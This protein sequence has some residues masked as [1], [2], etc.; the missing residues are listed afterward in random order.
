MK[1]SQESNPMRDKYD[2][3]YKAYD[4]DENIEF[5]M[6]EY[7]SW[8]IGLVDQIERDGTVVLRD[9]GK[10][11]VGGRTLEQAE[12]EITARRAHLAW[13]FRT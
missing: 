4:H 9:V 5:H 2:N 10:V 11:A 8:E 6:N 7:L 12:A 13:R 3:Q 1:P